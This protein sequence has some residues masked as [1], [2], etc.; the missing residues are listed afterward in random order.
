MGI[1]L[2]RHR[3]QP[4]VPGAAHGVI[5]KLLN[6]YD[7]GIIERPDDARSTRALLHQLGDRAED[8]EALIG[9]IRALM[10]AR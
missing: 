1:P 9:D 4:A 3:P 10:H 2:R 7:F 8:V 5:D 6:T